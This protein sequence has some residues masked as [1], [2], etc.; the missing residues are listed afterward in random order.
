MGSLSSQD[1]ERILELAV[2]LIETTDPNIGMPMLTA[3]I[4]ESLH[5]GFCLLINHDRRAGA[6]SVDAWAPDW[7]G[8]FGQPWLNDQLRQTVGT[9]PLA[10][11]YM[12][13]NDLTPLAATDVEDRLWWYRT[14]AYEVIHDQFDSV[15]EFCLPLPS[16][17]G[18]IR[19]FLMFR[20]PGEAFN[21]RDHA[22]A[23]R[24]QPLLAGAD[25]HIRNLRQWQ[26][27][28]TTDGIVDPAQAGLTPREITV[29]HL[30]ARG[31]TAGAI[32]HQLGISE[33]TAVKHKENLYRK[34]KTKDRLT[35]VL[36]A[37]ALGLLPPT[38]GSTV[39]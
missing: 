4:N 26:R 28:F 34:L 5:A 27:S 17:P 38:E 30:L 7:L 39:D 32:A 29:L 15:H 6:S 24:V 16:R 8:R 25:R 37:Q 9:C 22:F 36:Q 3:Q 10:R 18:A 11:H 33:R 31:L 35:T 19:T 23:E 14:H 20:P 21:E 12:E 1:Y 2:A 13:T